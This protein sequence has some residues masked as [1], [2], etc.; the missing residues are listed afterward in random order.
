[1]PSRRECRSTWIVPQWVEII[2]GGEY[3][4][5]CDFTWYLWNIYV[6]KN[7]MKKWR[8]NGLTSDWT[9][10]KVMVNQCWPMLPVKFMGAKLTGST[11]WVKRCSTIY[12]ID[13]NA[14][15]STFTIRMSHW[16]H[17]MVDA[18]EFW[19][20]CK[21]LKLLRKADHLHLIQNSVPCKGQ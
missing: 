11:N 20:T 4:C 21:Q 12:W 10:L 8:W 9:I 3:I 18:A 7:S 2:S 19:I 13:S 14:G 15:Y 1:M 6:N 17:T 5:S 16:H